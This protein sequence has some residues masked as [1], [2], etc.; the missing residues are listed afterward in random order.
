MQYTCVLTLPRKQAKAIDNIH[1][2]NQI[3]MLGEQYFLQWG[4]TVIAKN[5]VFGA[6][7]AGGVQ[8]REVVQRGLATATFICDLRSPQV[9]Q[10]GGIQILHGKED[11]TDWGIYR[12]IQPTGATNRG[13]SLVAHAGKVLQNGCETAP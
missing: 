5:I 11:P 10:H 2:R 9:C 7:A 3:E 4:F 8:T 13:I 12:G 1:T 6:C